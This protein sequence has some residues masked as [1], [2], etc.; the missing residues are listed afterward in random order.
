MNFFRI[1]QSNF[2]RVMQYE[3]PKL[4][5]KARSFIPHQQ[6]SSAAQ[7]KLKELKEADTGEITPVLLPHLLT[8]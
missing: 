5:Q 7:H 4:Q 8:S 6:L 1:L 3:D 2:K